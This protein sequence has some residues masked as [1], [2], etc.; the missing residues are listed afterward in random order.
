MVH[1]KG[2][3]ALGKGVKLYSYEL[4][5]QYR[6][7]SFNSWAE[8]AEQLP[9][10]QLDKDVFYKEFTEA[11][12]N[13]RNDLFGDFVQCTIIKT[14]VAPSMKSANDAQKANF[15]MAHVA[16]S[17]IP[18]DR[19]QLEGDLRRIVGWGCTCDYKAGSIGIFFDEQLYLSNQFNFF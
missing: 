4:R 8:Y 10:L 6:P 19:L 5:L 15:K 7:E 11:P 17:Q 3:H 16:I 18:S 2:P 1:C 12:E 13:W 14:L 9:N